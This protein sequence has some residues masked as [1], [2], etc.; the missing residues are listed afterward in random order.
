MPLIRALGERWFDYVHGNH[1]VYNTCWEDPRL[2]HEVLTLD[3]SATVLVITSA[4]C[5]ALDY[6][7]RSPA[8]VYAVDM[9]PR[10]NAL[11]ELKVAALRSCDHAV[12]FALFGRGR[13]PGARSLYATHL[14]SGLSASARAFWDTRIKWFDG[15]VGDSFYFHGTTGMFARAVNLY[16]DRISRVRGPMS[17]MLA[18]GSIEEQ[19]HIYSREF[20]PSFWRPLL[21]KGLGTAAVLALLGVPGPQRAQLERTCGGLPRFVE[22]RIA[23]VFTRLPLADNYFYRVYLTGSYTPACCPEYLRP[24]HF[25]CLRDNLD[26]LHIHTAPI[27]RFLEGHTGRIT[28]YVLLDHMDWLCAHRLPILRGEWQAMLDRADPGARFIWRSGGTETPFVDAL[29]VRRGGSTV[30]VAEL[31]RYQPD[32]T[33]SLHSR[34]RVSTYGSFHAAELVA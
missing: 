27:Q 29:E 15:P 20:A 13:L 4:G 22:D 14:R 23:H 24:E 18:A 19:E 33:K 21:R 25:E 17:A 12:L 9:N 26:R 1:L 32:V 28:R 16:I 11:L 2:D 5:N 30:R 10:Q 31:L 8:A 7:I 34:D 3:R 6:L